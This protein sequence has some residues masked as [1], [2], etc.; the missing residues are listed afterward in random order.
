MELKNR[1]EN[2][3]SLVI[4]VLELVTLRFI[5]LYGHRHIRT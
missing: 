1:Q 2:F 3:L 4:T 5:S